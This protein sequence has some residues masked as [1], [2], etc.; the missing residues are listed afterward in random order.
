MLSMGIWKQPMILWM[1]LQLF[2]Q[3]YAGSAEEER[4]RKRDSGFFFI[5]LSHSVHVGWRYSRGIPFDSINM[6][7]HLTKNGNEV[8]EHSHTILRD[9]CRLF[10]GACH[11]VDLS[12]PWVF[13][14]KRVTV[15]E[16]LKMETHLPCAWLFYWQHISSHT[17]VV[18]LTHSVPQLRA[19]FSLGRSLQGQSHETFLRIK[20]P[21]CLK[22]LKMLN[23][24]QASIPFSHIRVLRSGSSHSWVN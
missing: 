12:S 23:F 13:P 5:Q 9:S 10:L 7:Q 22:P 15:M 6:Q 21:T 3:M 24:T 18:N 20:P 19:R 2:S 14:H 16:L 8:L 1:C 17:I 11:V 4:D